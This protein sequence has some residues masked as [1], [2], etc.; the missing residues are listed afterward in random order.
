MCY[1]A[2]PNMT[3]GRNEYSGG[4]TV[5]YYFQI[6]RKTKAEIFVMTSTPVLYARCTWDGIRKL[7]MMT[8]HRAYFPNAHEIATKLH[9]M[10]CAVIYSENAH[11]VATGEY[12]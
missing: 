1:G 5:G 7:S 9:F 11:R 4:S 2:I 10:A 12:S 8:F 3:T 6:T